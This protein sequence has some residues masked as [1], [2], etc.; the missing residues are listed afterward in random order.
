MKYSINQQ[1]PDKVPSYHNA[2]KAECEV[3]KTT[4]NESQY[5]NFFDTEVTTIHYMLSY[6]V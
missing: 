3:H 6:F 4:T 2:L 5:D 1:N